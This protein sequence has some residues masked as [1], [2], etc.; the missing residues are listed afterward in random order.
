MSNRAHYLD[1]PSI[2]FSSM[3]PRQVEHYTEALDGISADD[4]RMDLIPGRHALLLNLGL[5]GHCPLHE[6]YFDI[7]QV[8]YDMVQLRMSRI[9][10][11]LS[12]RCL[13]RPD[14]VE[15]VDLFILNKYKWDFTKEPR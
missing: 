13:M 6:E 1:H 15:E 11:K 7:R 3:N 14:I 12:T 5:A 9:P 2:E 8:R 10:K 4:I